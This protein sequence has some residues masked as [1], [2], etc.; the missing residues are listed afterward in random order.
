MGLIGQ[1]FTKWK[2]D[3]MLIV[4]TI[5]DV[6]SLT[7][8]TAEWNLSVDT[9]STKLLTKTSAGGTITF[10]GNKAIVTVN[11]AE[12]N[13]NVTAI[14]AGSYYHELQLIDPNGKK[15]VAATGTL[16]LLNP[17]KKRT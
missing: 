12:T 4:F 17:S 15:T 7:G 14:P 13:Q 5:E 2:G 3:D 11:S 6:Q 9:E 8:Y 16:T 10:E 1:N